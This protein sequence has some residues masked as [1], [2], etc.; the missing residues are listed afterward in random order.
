MKYNHLKNIG[1]LMVILLSVISCA[2]EVVTFNVTRSSELKIDNVE[3]IAIGNFEDVLGENIPL[4]KGV[5]KVKSKQQINAFES[6]QSLSEL[7]RAY[8]ISEISKGG[9]YKIINSTG[10]ETGYSGIIPDMAKV[11]VI[12]ARIKYYEHTKEANDKKFFVLLIT[13]NGMPMEK[14]LIVAGLKI[15]AVK[16]AENSGKGFKIPVPYVERVGAIEVDFDLIRKSNGKKIVPTQTFRFYNIKKWGG[17]EDVSILAREIKK[18]ILAK[19]NIEESILDVITDE[20]R[21][22]A[23]ALMDSDEYLAKGYHLKNN[24]NVP[25]LKLDLRQILASSVAQQFARKISKYHV[26]EE[27]ELA[28]GGDA[29]GVNLMKGNAYDKAI[30]HLETLSKPLDLDDLYNL[31]LSYESM[32]EYPQALNYYEQG[33][34]AS[35]GEQRF[36]FGIK[37]VK[38]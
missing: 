13:N 31:A 25:L 2:K 9:E 34:D 23:L 3:L 10:E 19:Y 17:D 24:S 38:R 6:N 26:Q 7:V 1:L 21:K 5:G 15:I 16:A 11:G 36:K 14:R 12:N 35:D 32:G 27:I 37:R 22:S 20:A 28:S 30:G 4:P 33:L 8:I 18:A 29:I